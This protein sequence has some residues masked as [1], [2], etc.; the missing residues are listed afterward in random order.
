MFLYLTQMFAVKLFWDGKVASFPPQQ[1]F[2]LYQ[3]CGNL[4]YME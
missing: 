3:I 2:N 1:N 4:R